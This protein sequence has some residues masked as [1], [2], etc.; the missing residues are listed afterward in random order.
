MNERPSRLYNV[1]GILRW[2]NPFG[3]GRTHY[4]SCIV[5][6]KAYMEYSGAEV[7]P[8]LWDTETQGTITRA[9]FEA[10]EQS[11]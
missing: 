3:E 10:I 1:M 2:G 5:N 7:H 9:Q 4:Q 11:L 6:N 8:I